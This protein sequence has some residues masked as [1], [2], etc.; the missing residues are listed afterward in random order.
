MHMYYGLT[1]PYRVC[2]HGHVLRV[3]HMVKSSTHGPTLRWTVTTILYGIGDCRDCQFD[4]HLSNRELK[5]SVPP[6]TAIPIDPINVSYRFLIAAEG[7]GS[8]WKLRMSLSMHVFMP[9]C[10]STHV[11]PTCSYKRPVR[12][13]HKRSDEISVERNWPVE[14]TRCWLR[15]KP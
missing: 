3:Q 15:L 1:H 11:L 12:L 8:R 7:H 6:G 14:Y 9:L 2:S 13:R 10:S 5:W 4:H